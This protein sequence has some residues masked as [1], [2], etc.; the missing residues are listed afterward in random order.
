[1][2]VNMSDGRG[3]W[4][5]GGERKGGLMR[6]K[7]CNIY[8]HEDSIMKTKRGRS[9]CGGYTV[10]MYRTTTVKPPCI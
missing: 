6:I 5:G 8:T 9:K 7:V 2:N 3:H 10:C 1:M 4:E